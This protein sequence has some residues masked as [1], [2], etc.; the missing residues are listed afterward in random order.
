MK[1]VGRMSW[2]GVVATLA[3]FFGVSSASAGVVGYFGGCYQGRAI[4]T[5]GDVQLKAGWAASDYGLTKKFLE[6][7]SVTLTVNAGRPIR[8]SG[9]PRAPRSPPPRTVRG[10]A[11]NRH[12]C[13]DDDV[14]CRLRTDS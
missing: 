12:E 4:T 5:T 11:Q 13:A 6:L 1:V 8:V 14:D 7:Q 2:V 10:K 9:C 3:L